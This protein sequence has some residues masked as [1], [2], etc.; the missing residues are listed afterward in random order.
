MHSYYS[1][2][3]NSVPD[4]LVSNISNGLYYGFLSDHNTGRGLS[5]WAQG[6]RMTAYIDANDD[7]RLFNA[8]DAVEVTTEFGHYQTLGL[9][10][11]FDLYEVLLRESERVKPTAEKEAI[12]KEKIR[13]IGET[14]KWAGGVAQINHPFSTSTMGFS[15]WD[16]IDAFDTIEIWN[17][18]FHPGDGRYEPEQ[19]VSMGQGILVA[20]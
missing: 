4:V 20:R 10:L 14:I 2:G 17:G 18:Y 19:V 7:E 1:D 5:E 6:N 12:I 13:Y 3:V 9:G 16:T 15:A 8:Y 11:T